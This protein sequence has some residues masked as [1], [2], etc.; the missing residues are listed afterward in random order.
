MRS[1]SRRQFVR[2]GA[3][4]TVAGL[5]AIGA[6][7]CAT[8]AA[9][10]ERVPRSTQPNLLFVFGD[11]W[12]RQAMGFM[13]EDPV[14][15]SCI[16]QFAQQSLVFTNAISSCPVCS[17]YR[18]SLLT[19][20]YPTS[21]GVNTNDVQLPA[22]E[23]TIAEVLKQAGYDTGYIGKWHLDGGPRNGFTP[24]GRRQGFNFWYANECFHNHFE[25][26]YY[27]DTAEPIT[28][29]GW[30]PDHETNIVID[31][32]KTHRK[33]KP[34]ALFLSWGAPHTLEGVTRPDP[35]GN[36]WHYGAPER[37]EALYKGK[38][39]P[40]RPNVPDNYA[41]EDLPGYFG[42]ITSLDENFGR[43]LA[44]LDEQGL[45][46]NTIVVL[47]SDHG[48]MMGSHRR[49]TKAIW[50]EES[51]GIPFLIRYPGHVKAGREN[52]IFSDVDVM[53][54]LLGL[55]GLPIPKAV[56]GTDFSRAMR[57]ELVTKPESALI[58]VFALGRLNASWG[59]RGIRTPRYTYV[60]YV[61]NEDREEV[62]Y[63][64]VTDPYQMNPKYAQKGKYPLD[65]ALW[66]ELKR[67]LEKTND[68][69]VT[70][71]KV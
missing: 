40:R 36:L 63:D 54:S 47:T 8:K 49:M 65:A 66:Q 28:G 51:I 52:L 24:P 46:E 56:E 64:N 53:P 67:W 50:Y 70:E 14:L 45:T 3:G 15:T 16:D 48:E 12:R 23:V 21:N 43:L 29:H 38:P 17:P 25:L 35:S 7:G 68:P 19:G 32:I 37:F 34:F 10:P 39:L 58:E 11:Q 22:A 60:V 5:A 18:A 13:N 42:S 62:L 20:R 59:W 27:R 9:L 30:Q 1:I 55:M 2:F 57:G 6:S 33:D 69:W 41:E 4:A 71:K 61:G 31:Y 44:C 26:F